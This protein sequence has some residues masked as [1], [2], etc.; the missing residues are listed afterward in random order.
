MK[1]LAAAACL[2]ATLTSSNRKAPTAVELPEPIYCGQDI[3][4]HSNEEVFHQTEAVITLLITSHLL[5]SYEMYMAYKDIDS[6][7]TQVN[8]TSLNNTKRKSNKS[9]FAA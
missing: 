5:Q 4:Q 9:Q 1:C 3:F 2:N 6:G 8:L 7:F